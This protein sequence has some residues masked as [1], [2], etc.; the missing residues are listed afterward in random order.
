M[1]FVMSP[2]RYVCHDVASTATAAGP[3]R[4]HVR[5]QRRLVLR[6]VLVRRDRRARGALHLAC[7]GIAAARHV[8]VA[9]LR[10]DC[11]VAV[12]QQEVERVGHQTARAP[13]RSLVARPQAPAPRPTSACGRQP[14]MRLNVARRRERPAAA[15]LALVL[16]RGHRSLRAPVNRVSSRRVGRPPSTPHVP[17][18]WR[19]RRPHC[20]TPLN[21]LRSH[22]RE[23]GRP[24]LSQWVQRLPSV[25]ATAHVLLENSAGGYS[26]SLIF[27]G[28]ESA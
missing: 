21:S 23:R 28:V 9:R 20:G 19:S 12:L 5:R 13:V 16:H 6:Q 15:A 14:P 25:A 7:W 26:V 11:A 24:E 10:H 17:S 4:E 2:P 22:V 8:R 18:P 1:Q 27:R 3:A